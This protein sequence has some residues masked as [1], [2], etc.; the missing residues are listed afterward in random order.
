MKYKALFFDFDGTIVDT[1]ESNFLAYSKAIND[2]VPGQKFNSNLLFEEIINGQNYKCFLPKVI[3]NISLEDM[4][5][6]SERKTFWY[7]KFTSKSKVNNLVVEFI[8]Q[9]KKELDISIVLVTTAK[10]A[11]AC[12]IIEHHSLEH[13]FDIMFFGDDITRLKPFPDIYN[14]ALNK[15]NLQPSQVRAYEDSV[16]GLKAA[17]LAK[18]DVEKVTWNRPLEVLV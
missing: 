4:E 10:K 12:Y 14:Y 6:I 1:H 16:S 18:I 5:R 3:S 8:C 2:I 15:M 11:N 13:L 7:K 9:I 17:K